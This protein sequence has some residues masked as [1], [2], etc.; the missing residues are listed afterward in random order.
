MITEEGGPARRTTC[1]SG[2]VS[3]TPIPARLGWQPTA[4]GLRLAWQLVIDDS[5]APHLWNATVDA[6]TG[7]L[8]DIADWTTHD[9]IEELQATLGQISSSSSRGI[10]VAPPN[11]VIDGSSYRVLAVPTES[12]N[13]APRALIDNP[14]DGDASPFGWHDTD[15][16][17]GAEFTLTRGNNA[18]AYL[19]QDANNQPDFGFDVEGGASLDFD[20]PADL[21]EH[22]QSYR[23]AVGTNLFYGC[24]VIHD[25]TWRYG[26]NEAS[27]NFQANNYGRGGVQGD[28]VRCEAADGGGTNNANFSTPGHGRR[29]AAHADVPLAGEPVR[30]AE[31]GRRRRPRV[32][33][34]LLGALLPPS[35]RGRHLGCDHQRG[36]RL[37]GRRLRGRAARRLDGHRHR[38]QHR[39]PEHPEGT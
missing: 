15:G 27:G 24:N 9:P 19:E 20:F 39:L 14:A 5:S 23:S 8:L 4:S 29:D 3:H 13:D 7:Q 1:S 21:G 36:Q 30:A 22:A 35:Q 33:R 6:A 10:P 26:F 25:I 12:P 28:Y 38:Q 2:G 37:R 16:A 18:H 11:P 31:R 17:V 32:L 34:L